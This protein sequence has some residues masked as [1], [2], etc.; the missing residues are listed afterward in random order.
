MHPLWAE[1]RGALK[2]PE[3][4]HVVLNPIPVYGLAVAIAAFVAA[5]VAGRR[6]AQAIA[7]GL[8][9]LTSAAAGPAAYFGH[10]GYDRV[11]SLSDPSAQKWLNWHENLGERVVWVYYSS[12][13][14]SCLAALCLWKEP[15]FQ[16]PANALAMAAATAALLSGA[17]LAL[18]GGKIRHPEF[19][20]RSPPAWADTT[21]EN[22]R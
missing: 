16:R 8:I 3:Y 15:R 17:F 20:D 11:Y 18:V 19:R 12:A 9:I 21:G 2:Q 1:F 4:L 13:A 5:W 14:I 7:L 22:D 10:Q 6:S